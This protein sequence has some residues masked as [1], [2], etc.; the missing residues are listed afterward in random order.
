MERRCGQGNNEDLCSRLATF[1]DGQKRLAMYIAEEKLDIETN[2]DLSNLVNNLGIMTVC[3]AYPLYSTKWTKMLRLIT[4][5][6]MFDKPP[7]IDETIKFGNRCALLIVTFYVTISI[8]YEFNSIYAGKSCHKLAEQKGL[9]KIC[10]TLYP[11]WLPF[12]ISIS[13]QI[14]ISVFQLVLILVCVVPAGVGIHLPWEV[15]QHLYNHVQHLNNQFN[16]IFETD[17]KEEQRRRLNK[18]IKYHNRIV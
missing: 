6:R 15:S 4:D 8:M 1:G 2:E 13:S 17:D 9:R 10:F 7:K 3:C 11:V 16:N 12:E 18:W 14:M 5:Y